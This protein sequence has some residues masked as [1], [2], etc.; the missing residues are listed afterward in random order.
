M[1]RKYRKYKEIHVLSKDEGMKPSVQTPI[2]LFYQAQW[3]NVMPRLSSIFCLM[4]AI[5]TPFVSLMRFYRTFHRGL[6]VIYREI[7]VSNREQSWDE[8]EMIMGCGK[9]A[10]LSF[11]FHLMGYGSLKYIV[12]LQTFSSNIPKKGLTLL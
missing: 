7:H 10:I 12:S 2:V 11:L 9:I 5:V 4:V 6:I 8:R 3:V 1:H